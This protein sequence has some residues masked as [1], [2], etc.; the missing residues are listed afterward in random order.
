MLLSKNKLRD[1]TALKQRKNRE[2]QQLFTIEGEK[3]VQ[4]ILRSNWI[5]TCICALPDWIDKNKHLLYTIKEVYEVTEDQLHKISNLA[6]PN[7]VLAIAQ[8]PPIKKAETPP[9]NELSLLL[10]DIQDPG[11]LGTI[12]RLAD[13]FGIGT[14]ACTRDTVEVYNPKVIQSTMGAFLRVNTLYV[15]SD[16]WL[17]KAKEQ[18]LDIFGTFLEGSN[19][20]QEKLP[21][22][23]I[24]IMGN[25]SKGISEKLEMLTDR[26]ITIPSFPP[27]RQG[28]ES[29][30]VAIAA[31]IVCAEFRR[32][33][34]I[35]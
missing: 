25:E 34:S 17:R 1:I 19:L 7:K 22:K 11:N 26:K 31:S 35:L 30:N 21:S 14:V 4:E 16:E 24:I 29:L 3:V 28:S 18:Q 20:Y 6:T 15:D 23:G 5:V 32:Q 10:D 9:T 8:I 2:E 33:N 12:I 27:E 13:W